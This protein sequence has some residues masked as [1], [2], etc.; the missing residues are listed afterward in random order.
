MRIKERFLKITASN[1]FANDQTAGITNMASG[2][3]VASVAATGVKSGDVILANPYMYSNA[4]V[5]SG[6]GVSF[7]GLQVASVRSGAFEIVAVGSRAPVANMP[8]AWSVFRK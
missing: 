4:A 5:A 3:T 2:T 6:S 7:I 8:I 1:L